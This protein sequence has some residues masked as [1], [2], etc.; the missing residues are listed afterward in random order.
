MLAFLVFLELGGSA[1]AAAPHRSCS[2]ALTVVDRIVELQ[3][4]IDQ[5]IESGHTEGTRALFAALQNRILMAKRAGIDVSRYTGAKVQTKAAEVLRIESENAEKEEL[6]ARDNSGFFDFKEISREI[7]ARTFSSLNSVLS[8]DLKLASYRSVTGIPEV[9]DTKSGK[10]LLR[11]RSLTHTWKLSPNGDF[12]LL[13]LDGQTFEI[14]STRTGALVNSGSWKGW[15]RNQIGP[16]AQVDDHGT[17]IAYDSSGRWLVMPL[18]K[19]APDFSKV[20]QAIRSD[21][22]GLGRFWRSDLSAGTSISAMILAKLNKT[23]VQSMALSKN[24]RYIILRVAEQAL[25]RAQVWDSVTGTKLGTITGSSW[26]ANGVYQGPA[27]VA[28]FAKIHVSDDGSLIA[29]RE[30]SVNLT[31]YNVASGEIVRTFNFPHPKNG[32]RA[33][34]ISRDL[35]RFFIA[36]FGENK[37]KIF[38]LDNEEPVQELIVDSKPRVM[39]YDDQTETLTTVD[40]KNIQIRYRQ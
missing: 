31:V 40:D 14:H 21:T 7:L 11:R 35:K 34:E 33:F 12:A 25:T 6:L 15:K 29:I 4:K 9:A 20:V 27:D 13:T 37:I 17:L 2:V 38:E 5:R 28:N 32:I 36:V 26:D 16:E 24:G 22:S 39:S 1:A 19:T 8:D 30:S 18:D 3:A 10:L 23:R